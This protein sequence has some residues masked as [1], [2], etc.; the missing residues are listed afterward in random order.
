MNRF[1]FIRQVALAVAVMSVLEFALPA[2][3]AHPVPFKGR[4]AIEVT[5]DVI[6]PP[7]RTLTGSATGEATHL[8]RFTRTETII[9]DLTNFSFTG[10][11]VF[12]AANG[13]SL[14]ANVVGQF[15]SLT[16]AV[17]AYS[18]TGG[19]G[20]FLHASGQAAFEATASGPG[21][22]D[23]TFNGTIQY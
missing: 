7:I 19:T 17:G 23:V 22:F 12:T 1:S 6:T 13:D 8:G 5:G 20:R 14:R 15:T 16:T 18:F 4:A 3:A 9:V 2:F 10:T 21:R 11:V